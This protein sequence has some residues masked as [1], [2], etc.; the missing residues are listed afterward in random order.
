MSDE[1]PEVEVPAEEVAVP[2]EQKTIE[3]QIAEV[4]DAVNE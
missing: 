2:E 1:N 3:E 4:P